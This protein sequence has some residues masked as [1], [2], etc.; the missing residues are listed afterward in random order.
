MAKKSLIQREKKRER[1]IER[2]KNRREELKQ[3]IR[4]ADSLEEKWSFHRKLQALPRDSAPNRLHNRCFL[5]GRPRAYSRDF[6]L[7]RHVVRK[8]AHEG[9][10]PGVTK[11]SW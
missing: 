5:T 11:S 3:L 6:G 2:Y 8:M 9:E 1:L 4:Q 7:S 10:L